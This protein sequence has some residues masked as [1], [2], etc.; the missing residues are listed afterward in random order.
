MGHSALL[1]ISSYLFSAVPRAG[2]GFWEV[3]PDSLEGLKDHEN[4]Q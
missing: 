2:G 3:S 1:A 4:R